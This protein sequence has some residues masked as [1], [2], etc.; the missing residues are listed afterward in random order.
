MYIIRKSKYTEVYQM[1]REG[2]PLPQ[3]SPAPKGSHHQQGLSCPSRKPFLSIYEHGG[4][5]PFLYLHQEDCP[6]HI[7]LPLAFS[8]LVI[9]PDAFLTSVCVVASFL[10]HSVA[11]RMH[12]VPHL[13]Y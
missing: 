7:V 8:L 12:T 2:P 5:F 9:Y 10:K 11:W 1:N 13:T 3:G 4:A 6:S